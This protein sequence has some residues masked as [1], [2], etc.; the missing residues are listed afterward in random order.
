MSTTLTSPAEKL[1]NYQR[2]RMLKF[3]GQSSAIIG[4][5]D[6]DKYSLLTDPQIVVTAMKCAVILGR[7]GQDLEEFFRREF[8][9]TG[10]TEGDLGGCAAFISL[11]NIE[12]RIC[13]AAGG[14]N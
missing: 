8:R 11:M 7:E 12:R 3:I 2:V 1:S 6:L 9:I 14:Q 5:T 13:V 10:I 4:G